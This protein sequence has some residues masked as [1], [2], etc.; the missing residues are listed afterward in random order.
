MALAGREAAAIGAG[1]AIIGAVVVS[2]ATFVTD[3][4]RHDRE[5]RE[6]MVERRRDRA[7]AL[8]LVSLRLDE[9]LQDVMKKAAHAFIPSDHLKATDVLIEEY[10]EAV[11]QF[12]FFASEG[13]NDWLLTE[14]RSAQIE[15]FKKVR[16][17]NSA[18]GKD[19]GKAIDEAAKALAD[20]RDP[21]MRRLRTEAGIPAD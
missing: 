5:R 6:R 4:K 11:Y 20:W 18:R 3:A 15:A 2:V 19:K 10:G 16:T 9:E 12:A 7:L 21:L 17:A 8:F 1:G 13:T 14:S